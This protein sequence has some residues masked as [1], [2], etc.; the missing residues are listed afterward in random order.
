MFNKIGHVPDM[1]VEIY[2]A[3][4]GRSLVVVVLVYRSPGDIY[5]YLRMI[6]VISDAGRKAWRTQHYPVSDGQ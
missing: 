3:V 2:G 6:D 4:S 5:R 1:G